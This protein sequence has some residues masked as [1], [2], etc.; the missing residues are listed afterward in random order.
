MP[1]NNTSSRMRPEDR[2][3]VLLSGCL[4]T[5]NHHDTTNV[6]TIT[7]NPAKRIINNLWKWK[8]LDKLKAQILLDIV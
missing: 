4:N 1:F 6:Y 7:K 8:K 5:L 2:Q 3:Q